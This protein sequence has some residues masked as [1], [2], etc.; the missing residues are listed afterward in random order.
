MKIRIIIVFLIWSA[1]LWSQSSRQL[2]PI[3]VNGTAYKNKGWFFS[4]GITTMF[5][6]GRNEGALELADPVD[7][8]DTLYSGQFQRRGKIGLYLEGG[9]HKFID[10]FY[11]INHIDY[12]AHFKM[13]RGKESFNGDIKSSGTVLIPATYDAKFSE[14]FVGAFVN[15]SNIMQVS[16][17]KWI[18]NSIGANGDFRVISRRN[19][20][21]VPL[22]PFYNYPSNLL[23]QLHY[24]IGFGW[25]PEP[26]IYIMPMIETPILSVFPFDDG[27]SSLQY[28]VGR[29]RPII[30]TIRIQ[31][32]DK[33]ESRKCEGQPGGK[34]KKVDKEKPGKSK[35]KSIFGP[36]YKKK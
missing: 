27:K 26:G 10:N 12:G 24:K 25:K 31:F 32:L 16:N 21:G 29:Y 23:F 36:D 22:T 35:S 19:V 15:V 30:F 13:L 6:S 2:T 1:D 9:R 3:Y 34:P 7:L 8:R 11:L 20:E 28:F 5:A 17:D 18:Q 33:T 4:P 14:S